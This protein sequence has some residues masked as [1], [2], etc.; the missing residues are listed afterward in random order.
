MAPELLLLPEDIFS[1]EECMFSS[2]IFLGLCAGI[3]WGMSQRR[4]RI[5]KF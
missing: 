4:K 3:Y 5:E 2:L 1:Q